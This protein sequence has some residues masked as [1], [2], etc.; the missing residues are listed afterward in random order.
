[1]Y[2]ERLRGGGDD[3]EGGTP[4]Q[5]RRGVKRTRAGGS[6]SGAASRAPQKKRRASTRGAAAPAPSPDFPIPGKDAASEPDEQP[7]PSGWLPEPLARSSVDGP[8]G[9]L[10]EPLEGSTA[11]PSQDSQQAFPLGQ[12]LAVQGCPSEYPSNLGNEQLADRSPI[13]TGVLQD[14]AD[15]DVCTATRMHVAARK[16]RGKNSVQHASVTPQIRMS[17]KREPQ[18]AGRVAGQGASPP[19]NPSVDPAES[20]QVD[21]D[22]APSTADKQN[23]IGF[24]DESPVGDPSTVAGRLRPR[25][26][27][28]G[29]AVDVHWAAGPYASPSKKASPV[30]E[31]EG[32]LAMA[33]SL[34]IGPL[35]RPALAKSKART[36]TLAREVAC[37]TAALRDTDGNVGSSEM[38]KP[39]LQ[40]ATESGRDVDKGGGK[41]FDGQETCDSAQPEDSVPGQKE[42]KRKP[43]RKPGSGTGRGGGGKGGRG[44]GGMAAGK[45]SRGR[46]VKVVGHGTSR[47][48]LSSIGAEGLAGPFHTD[49][50]TM[51]AGSLAVCGLCQGGRVVSPSSCF[52]DY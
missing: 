4:Q 22:A 1:V 38:Q 44:R 37:P 40:T 50:Q 34:G 49:L 10:A 9:R 30:T 17:R 32:K 26:S 27:W 47:G 51:P 11:L 25:R 31:P 43:G 3:G 24:D 14:A 45:G 35:Q 20:I 19:K 15:T 2:T 52:L 18:S 46:G 39:R 12:D 23:K 28:K 8:L 42:P 7:G 13:T 33:A 36:A 29:A 16:R 6:A 5:R 21:T 48:G 41:A